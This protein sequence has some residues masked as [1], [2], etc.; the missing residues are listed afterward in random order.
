[1]NIIKMLLFVHYG[2]SWRLCLRYELVYFYIIFRLRGLWADIRGCLVSDDDAHFREE[3]PRSRDRTVGFY[4]GHCAWQLRAG[5][6]RR[7]EP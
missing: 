4:V 7:P 6:I 5:E 2:L 3:R 1:M